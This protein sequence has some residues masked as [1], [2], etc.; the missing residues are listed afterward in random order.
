[1]GK[2]RL[3]QLVLLL[4]A[5]LAAAGAAILHP[6][7]LA[8]RRQAK[9]DILAAD[10]PMLKDP[11][12]AM[13]QVAPGGLR[14]PVL[15]YLWIRSQN[16]K[17]QGKFYDAQQLRNLICEMM[18]NNGGVW[19][20]HAWDMAYNISVE[21]HTP[22]ERWNW[23]YS[24]IRLLRDRG[25]QYNPDDLL[26]HKELAW[27]FFQKIIETSDDMNLYYKQRLAAEMH[28]LL[29]DPPVSDQTAPVLEAFRAIAQ[30]PQSLAKLREDPQA[31]AFLDAAAP[32]GLQPDWS[33]LEAFNKFAPESSEAAYSLLRPDPATAQAKAAE[34]MTSP[35][36]AGGRA[37]V[38][39]FVR[40]DIL[41]RQYHMD[42]AWMMGLMD[43][44]GPLDWRDG[45]AHALY[46]ASM[47]LHRSERKS[48]D[49]INS[50]N[51]DRVVLNSLRNLVVKGQMTYV[52]DPKRPDEP[53]LIWMMDQ[54]FIE[55]ANREY[56]LGGN[57]LSHAEDKLDDP[58]NYLRDGHINFLENVV[59]FLYFGR[60]AEA[61]HY[62][63][64]IRQK[65]RPAGEDYKLDL[66]QFVRLK[67][68]MMGDPQR[69]VSRVIWTVSLRRAYMSL[70]SANIAEYNRNMDYARM[71][72]DNWKRAY[73]APRLDLEDFD[74]QDHWFLVRVLTRPQEVQLYLPL[75]SK[76]RLYEALP[77]QKKASIYPDVIEV[78]RKECQQESLDP[79]K[80]FPPPPGYTPPAPG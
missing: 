59:I 39:A 6:D 43:K 66:D 2:D 36:L 71:V 74:E 13:L 79:D 58:R 16:L 50:L 26:I 32:A 11:S 75:L 41:R 77:P 68:K 17:Q 23:I 27:L 28:R 60:Q 80:A 8:A 56:T 63:D 49:D 78:L 34:I 38:V 51:T 21:T 20:F 14:A 64:F 46:W 22:Q 67:L 42:P 69:D 25:L 4:V 10:S 73:S 15:S 9:L 3:V 57:M 54:R 53:K 35:E 62:L 52:P 1:M 55:P 40:A 44:Y 47:G 24:G 76:W 65:L 18:P 5:V 37:K 33:L 30:S 12:V 19:A 45:N 31:A 7:M 70:A 72:Y 61:Q 29:G 48:L